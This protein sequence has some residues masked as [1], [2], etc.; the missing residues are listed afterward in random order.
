ME[1]G[2]KSKTAI[3]LALGSEYILKIII[4]ILLTF[5]FLNVINFR[6]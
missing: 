3:V 5:T 1:L 4:I 2:V 6:L